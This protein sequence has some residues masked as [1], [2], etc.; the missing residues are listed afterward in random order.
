MKI[1][2]QTDNI[3]DRRNTL[4]EAIVGVAMG[5]HYC[6]GAFGW[7]TNTNLSQE[8]CDH[9]NCIRCWNYAKANALLEKE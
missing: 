1:K 8:D 6:P 3:C 7:K 2:I 9:D 5:M 4:I